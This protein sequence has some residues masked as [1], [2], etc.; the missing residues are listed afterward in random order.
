MEEKLLAPIYFIL[1]GR[2]PGEGCVITRDREKTVDVWEMNSVPDHPWFVLQ[3]N[4]D[5][6]V[7]PPFFDDR[8]DPGNYCMMQLGNEVLLSYSKSST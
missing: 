2:S 6:W 5:H 7:K 4:Y 8:S 3:T 1:G